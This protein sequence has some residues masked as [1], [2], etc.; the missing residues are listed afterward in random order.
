MAMPKV[1]LRMPQSVVEGLKVAAEQ[2]TARRGF[3]ITWANLVNELSTTYLR[4]KGIACEPPASRR[5]KKQ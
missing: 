5:G 2:E 3:V 1:N 4:E